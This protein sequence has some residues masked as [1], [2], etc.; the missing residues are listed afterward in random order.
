VST[1]KTETIRKN[2][3]TGTAIEILRERGILRTEEARDLHGRDRA[4]RELW[5]AKVYDG[6]GNGWDE[7]WTPYRC[8]DIGYGVDDGHVILPALGPVDW[9]GKRPYR[10]A[11]PVSPPV[12]DVLYLFDDEIIA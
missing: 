3:D 6:L 5:A 4:K 8:R 7:E 9:T 11:F 12:D 10:N 2:C 1:I